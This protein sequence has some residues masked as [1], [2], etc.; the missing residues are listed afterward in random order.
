MYHFMYHLVLYI[1][2]ELDNLIVSSSLPAGWGRKLL[3]ALDILPLKLCVEETARRKTACS[4]NFGDWKEI[5]SP[6]IC[7]KL[8]ID[9]VWVSML[10]QA[11]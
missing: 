10:Q 8:G 2:Y 7:D 5:S 9:V 4:E 3:P 11:G 6:K 1:I